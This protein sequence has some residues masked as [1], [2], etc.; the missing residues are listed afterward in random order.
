MDELDERNVD[1]FTN[2]MVLTPQ[3]Q[4]SISS[5]DRDRNDSWTE[6][7]THMLEEYG[8]RGTG[9]PSGFMT[10][11]QS[12][13][14]TAP[15]PAK[16]TLEIES[17]KIDAKDKL[18]KFGNAD[19]LE[20][21]WKTG[22]W[23]IVPATYYG[24]DGLCAARKDSE[25]ELDIRIPEFS[26]HPEA[27]DRLDD[28]FPDSITQV[29]AMRITA[30]TDYYMAC[31]SRTFIHRLFDD[32]KADSCLIVRDENIF[33]SKFDNALAEFR[34][35]WARLS[36]NIEYVDPILPKKEPNVYL[37]KHFRYSYQQE[38]RFTLTPHVPIEKLQTAYLELGSL[39]DCCEFV[40]LA[41][42]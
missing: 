6:L 13:Q 8:L 38:F 21:S 15:K 20:E 37:A 2:L 40:P 39:R 1:I 23:R 41:S 5:I 35:R 10:Y 42:Q 12:V 32:F 34:P 4:I 11:V 26:R 9:M 28:E 18:I 27:H 17:L 3:G 19:W 29:K 7:W 36:G 33:K 25:L 22:R 31:F 24:A 14:P 30:N 16:G